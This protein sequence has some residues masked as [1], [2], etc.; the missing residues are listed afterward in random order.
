MGSV[1]VAIEEMICSWCKSPLI[2]GRKYCSAACK[3]NDYYRRKIEERAVQL[4]LESRDVAVDRLIDEEVRKEG[5]KW[6][7]VVEN[8]HREIERMRRLMKEALIN[9][10]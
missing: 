7:T 8:C 9:G 10:K 3:T 2:R 4:L 5:L 1:G 6:K